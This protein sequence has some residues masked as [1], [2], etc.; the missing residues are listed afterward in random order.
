MRDLEALFPALFAMH[1]PAAAGGDV[2]SAGGIDWD[3]VLA[4]V[5]QGPDGDS[6]AQLRDLVTAHPVRLVRVKGAVAVEAPR[7]WQVAH[8]QLWALAVMLVYDLAAEAV[9]KWIAPRLPRSG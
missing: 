4:E 1:G 8:G 2:P 5:G 7:E 6:L 3:A 9:A